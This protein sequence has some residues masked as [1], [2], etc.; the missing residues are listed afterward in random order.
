M[1]AYL[2]T[3]NPAPDHCSTM[4]AVQARQFFK[5]FTESLSVLITILMVDVINGETEAH[6]DYVTC[7]RSERL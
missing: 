4:T 3:L 5:H 7:L 2:N 1:G 6:N